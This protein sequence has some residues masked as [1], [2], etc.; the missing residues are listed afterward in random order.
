MARNG[1]GVYSLPSGSVIANGDTSDAT[2]LNTPLADLET[3]MNTPRPIVAGGTGASSAAAALVN[4]GLTATATE[5]NYTDGVT[6]NIQTQLNAKQALDATLT[7][8]AAYNTSGL[9]T[10]TAPD[11]FTGRTITAGDSSVTVTNGNGVSGNPTVIVATDGVT[12]AKMQNVTA[13]SRL[14][15]RGSA[16]GAGDVEEITLGTGL[17]M[18]GTTLSG[19]AAAWTEVSNSATWTGG[20]QT[21][22]GLSGYS[23]VMVIGAGVTADISGARQLRIGTSGGG[24]LS[25]SIYREAEGSAVTAL[26]LSTSSA[27]ARSWTVTIYNFNTTLAAKGVLTSQSGI[28]SSGAA[29]IVSASAFDRLQVFNSTGNIDGGNLYVYGR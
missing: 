14:L 12:Y 21:I 28:T 17:S 13:A 10:Q 2:D 6:S 29:A 16:G 25:T 27:N 15:G 20:S 3:D 9:V 26:T 11:T 4:F 18:S 1:S 8:L 19:S 5:L 22:T 7:A 24:I 23:E